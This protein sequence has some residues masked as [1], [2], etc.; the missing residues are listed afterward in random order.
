VRF[1]RILTVLCFV[2][3]TLLAGQQK[4]QDVVRAFFKAEDDRRWLDAARILDLKSFEG[5]RR[6][7]IEG[8]R[9]RPDFRGP[10]VES[11]MRMDPDMPR[12]VAEF[13]VAEWQKHMR[14]YDLIAQDFARVPSVDSLAALSVEE[15]AARWL[16]ARGPEWRTEI[17]WRDS[18]NRRAMNCSGLPD[19]AARALQIRSSRE[20]RAVIRGAT[21]DS[22]SVSYV[23]IDAVYPRYASADTV[24]E[25]HGPLPRAI[26]LRKIAGVWRIEPAADLPNANGMGGMY[27]MAVA[28]GEGSLIEKPVVK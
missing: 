9:H 25:G 6:E 12:A 13:Q 21:S 24:E 17:S 8:V 7:L 18:R 3:P 22:G 14:E 27:A 2:S 23:V 19:S 5:I 26:R 10:T 11:L 20:P 15:A 1:S 28:C 16:E 4:P